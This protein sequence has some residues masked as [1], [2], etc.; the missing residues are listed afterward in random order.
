[1]PRYNELKRIAREA[2]EEAAELYKD[3]RVNSERSLQ[4]AVWSALNRLLA[5][6]KTFRLFVEPR[7]VLPGK[8]RWPQ[9]VRVPDIVVCNRDRAIAVIE[10]KF[11]PRGRPASKGDL[12]KFAALA[13]PRCKDLLVTHERWRGDKEPKH[14]PLGRDAVFIWMAI[15]A[16]TGDGHAPREDIA[17]RYLRLVYSTTTHSI[18]D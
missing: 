12:D 13:H 1:M 18:E 16:S 7:L 4:V 6:R 9:A 5:E 17:H 11:K 14:F 8:G 10:L 3:Q 2:F 15:G